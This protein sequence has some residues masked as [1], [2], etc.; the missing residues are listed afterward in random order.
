MN[1]TRMGADDTTVDAARPRVDPRGVDA[2][3]HAAHRLARNATLDER[4]AWHQAH[5]EACAC[6][7]MPAS[8]RAELERRRATPQKARSKGPKAASPAALDPRFASVV[9]SLGKARG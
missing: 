5:A 3:W 4:V 9:K 8:I 7:A 1:R 2:R 6:R